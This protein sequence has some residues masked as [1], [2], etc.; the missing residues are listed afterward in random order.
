MYI[1]K[2]LA[3]YI[4]LKGID[5]KQ[6]SKGTGIAYEALY[7]SLRNKNRNRPLR[8]DEYFAICRFLEKDPSEFADGYI[9]VNGKKYREI[10]VIDE[11]GALIASIGPKD[12]IE[13]KGTKVVCVPLD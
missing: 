8:A 1:T 4:E 7:D 12:V 13:E 5:I 6:I 9:I 3:A 2:R 10:N 11:D